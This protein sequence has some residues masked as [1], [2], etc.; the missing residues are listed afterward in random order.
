MGLFKQFKDMK[1]TVAAAPGMVEQ[2]QQ[3]Q[4]NAQQMQAASA[5]AAAQADAAASTAAGPDFEPIAG[6]TLEQYAE[7]SKGLAAVNYDQAQAPAIAAGMGISGENWQTAM[8]GWN[9][10]MA[11]NPAVAKRFNALYTGRA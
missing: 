9:A 2:A 5:A 8:D 4:Q 10:R 7:V 1:E 3:L 11:A 6:V